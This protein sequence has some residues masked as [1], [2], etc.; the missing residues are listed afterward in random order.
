M[1][2]AVVVLG[3]YS[4]AHLDVIKNPPNMTCGPMSPNF[5]RFR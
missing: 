5:G 4:N 1:S 2:N 3:I